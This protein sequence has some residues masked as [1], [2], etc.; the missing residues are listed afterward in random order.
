M[1]CLYCQ[2]ELTF[3]TTP[4]TGRDHFRHFRCQDCHA[5]F[6]RDAKDEMLAIFW[7]KIYVK[8]KPYFVKLRVSGPDSPKCIVYVGNGLGSKQV[9]C[10]DFIPR[11][12]TPQN[13]AAKLKAY[14]PFL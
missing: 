14:L 1:K 9:V 11:D 2:K 7:D 13:A 4:L 10:F 8:D 12:W 5:E 3:N 6:I